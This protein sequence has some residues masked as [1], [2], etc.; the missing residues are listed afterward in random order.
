MPGNM[1]FITVPSVNHWPETRCLEIRKILAVELK[2][3]KLADNLD[4]DPLLPFGYTIRKTKVDKLVTRLLNIY[5]AS[6]DSADVIRLQLPGMDYEVRATGGASWGESP[7]D[8]FDEFEFIN[9]LGHAVL[10]K[11]LEY[12]RADYAKRDAALSPT[13]S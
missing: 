3:R 13:P 1:L 11:L 7:N 4:D 12:A 2:Q 5:T 10:A 9:A 6:C 8:T